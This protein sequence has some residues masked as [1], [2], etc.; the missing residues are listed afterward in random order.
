M[1]AD[2]NDQNKFVAMFRF[3]LEILN[4]VFLIQ[5]NKKC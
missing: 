3:S 5:F 2:F 4:L 1:L